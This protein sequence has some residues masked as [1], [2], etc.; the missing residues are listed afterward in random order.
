MVL[1]TE[2]KREANLLLRGRAFA[3]QGD[4]WRCRLACFLMKKR[5]QAVELL[6]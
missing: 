1:L 6:S 4:H 2:W 5:S 3:S